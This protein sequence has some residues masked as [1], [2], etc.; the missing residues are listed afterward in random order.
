MK[1]V[2]GKDIPGYDEEEVV[3]SDIDIFNINQNVNSRVANGVYIGII[4]GL[5]IGIFLATIVISMYNW[6]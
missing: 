3:L 1:D 2:D 6:L 4:I 5:L